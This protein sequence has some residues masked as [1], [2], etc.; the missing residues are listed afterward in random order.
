M[1]NIPRRSH[2]GKLS[3]H[4]DVLGDGKDP[5]SHGKHPTDEAGQV[6]TLGDMIDVVLI[7]EG[8]PPQTKAYVPG[9]WS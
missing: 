5:T 6:L 8:R 2:K 4:V 7:H 3:A 9:L 1:P